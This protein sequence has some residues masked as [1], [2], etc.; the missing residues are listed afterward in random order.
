M[1]VAVMLGG[2]VGAPA[3]AVVDRAVTSHRAV[4]YAVGTLVVNTSGSLLFGLLTGLHLSHHLGS[5]GLTLFGT[6]FC[7]AYTTFST[8]TY[9]VVGLVEDGALRQAAVV[10]VA[11]VIGALLA[12]VAGTAIGLAL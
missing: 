5:L 6:G 9:E 11:G 3:R 1:I 7:G 8:F 4:P 12:A 10:V 2:L